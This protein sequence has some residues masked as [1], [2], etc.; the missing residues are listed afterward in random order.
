V[1]VCRR[2]CLLDSESPRSEEV[3]D[4]FNKDAAA[5]EQGLVKDSFAAASFNRC[6]AINRLISV[7]L[8]D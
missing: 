2:T 1:N 5:F 6:R 7:T 4:L 8:A 3:A